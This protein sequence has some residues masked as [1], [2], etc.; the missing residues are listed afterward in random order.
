MSLMSRSWQADCLRQARPSKRIKVLS[1]GRSAP[2]PRRVVCYSE[3]GSKDTTDDLLANLD[4]LL[5]KEPEPKK[6]EEA[7]PK[8]DQADKAAP[9]KVDPIPMSTST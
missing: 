7:E 3:K 4:A 1:A 5:G 8:T 2:Q 9:P 6:P